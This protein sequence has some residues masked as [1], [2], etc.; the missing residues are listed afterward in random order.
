[1]F[2]W[3]DIGGKITDEDSFYLNI[4]AKPWHLLSIVA[5]L[6]WEY[7]AE[8]SRRY[9]ALAFVL[10]S[11][12]EDSSVT[13]KIGPENFSPDPYFSADSRLPIIGLTS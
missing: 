7:Q 1:M 5:I 13:L 9:W 2:S 8:P 10:S 3:L 12:L 6:S 11:S 4:L